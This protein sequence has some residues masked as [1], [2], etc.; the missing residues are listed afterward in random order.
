MAAIHCPNC[1]QNPVPYPLSTK[2]GCG[3]QSYKIRCS[4]GLLWF[5]ALNHSSYLIRSINPSTRRLVFQTPGFSDRHSC[6]SADFP[7]GGLFLNNSLPF[8][9]SQSNTIM[10]FNC[11]SILETKFEFCTS[12]TSVCHTYLT[13]SKKGP[14]A[15]GNSNASLICCTYSP[16]LDKPSTWYRIRV[17]KE[18]CSMYQSFVNLDPSLPVSQW[19]EPGVELQWA[20]PDEPQC[21]SQE[22]CK[23]LLNSTCLI[24]PGNVER[25]RCFC[26][27]GLQWDPIN[28]VCQGNYLSIIK[29]SNILLINLI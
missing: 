17:H 13:Y 29:T 12:S 24:D 23:D 16:F 1:G 6:V 5:D 4:S 28:V 19:P 8:N 21:K 14:D 9:I 10:K 25:R 27:K 3:D 22:D 20:P 26:D 11:S 18:K 15:C 7:K 2:P